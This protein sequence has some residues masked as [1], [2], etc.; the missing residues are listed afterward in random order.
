[1]TWAGR[2]ANSRGRARLVTRLLPAILFSA[3]LGCSAC[4]R[5]DD[6]RGQDPARDWAVEDGFSLKVD[7]DGFQFPSALAFVPQPGPGPKDPLYFVTE[8]RGRLKVVTND[9]TVYTFADDVLTSRPRKELPDLQG[10]TGL[11]GICLEPKRGYVFVTFAYLDSTGVLRN[12]I[13]RLQSTPGT[14]GTRATSSSAFTEI[15]SSYEAAVSHQIGA[16][17]V[18]DDMLY[19]SVADGRQVAQSQQINS[20]LG[21]ILRMTLDG[22]PVPTNPFYKDED[23]KRSANYVWAYGLRNP[24]GLKI[25][26]GRVLVAE[27]GSGIDRF[28]EVRAGENYLWNGSDWSVGVNAAA[29]LPVVGPVQVDYYAGGSAALPARYAGRYFIALSAPK[30]TG[31]LALPYDLSRR[32]MAGVPSHFVKFVGEGTQ[33]VAGVGVGPDGLYFAPI[34]PGRGGRSAVFKVAYEPTRAHPVLVDHDPTVLIAEHGCVGCHSIDGSGGASAPP[35]DRGEL[36]RRLQSRLESAA[37]TDALAA[38]DRLDQ[39][40]YAGYRAARANLRRARGEDRVRAWLKFR[41]MEPRFDDPQAQMPNLGLS[42]TEA[43][44]LAEY[45][46]EPGDRRPAVGLVATSKEA[47]VGFLPS[48]IGPRELLLFWGA[49]LLMGGTGVAMFVWLRRLLAR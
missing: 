23:V 14:F 2:P 21:K 18:E 45:L 10:E 47:L 15:F 37:Y 49:G 25:R 28:M 4:S 7:A 39:E 8:L 36:T 1:V 31:V 34:M 35:L 13:V 30:A 6:P 11:A 12:N 42:P 40:P 20:V 33:A 26:G 9:R 27:N 43:A 16:C 5:S 38:V 17:Q 44:T 48:R 46:M 3:F 19:V 32:H 24:F 22:R 29:V 41:L